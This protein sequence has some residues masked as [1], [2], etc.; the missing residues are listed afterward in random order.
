[1]VVVVMQKAAL[2]HWRRSDVK[3]E[4]WSSVLHSLRAKCNGAEWD[5][6]GP[7]EML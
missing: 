4:D 2:M 5:L 3:A 1:M 6:L 7:R